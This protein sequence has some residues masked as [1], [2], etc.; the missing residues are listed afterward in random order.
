[1]FAPRAHLQRPELLVDLFD[2]LAH[3]LVAVV[4]IVGAGAL[5]QA[6]LLKLQCG[7][8]DV[9]NIRHGL[10]DQIVLVTGLQTVVW[11]R[12]SCYT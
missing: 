1:M 2:L 3:I 7:R 11:Q 10:D 6:L 12:T 8:K 4:H 5:L 9:Y